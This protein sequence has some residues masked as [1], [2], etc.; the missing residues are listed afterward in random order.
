MT[1]LPPKHTWTLTSLQLM[2]STIPTTSSNTRPVFLQLSDRERNKHVFRRT[3]TG[4]WTLF[5][6]QCLHLK[7][8]FSRMLTSNSWIC[9]YLRWW[10]W[11]CP[12]PAACFCCTWRHKPLASAQC[13]W[14]PGP[15]HLRG[16][17]AGGGDKKHQFHRDFMQ[18][19][20]CVTPFTGPQGL[21]HKSL[22]KS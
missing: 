9:S 4:T 19:C 18:L 8:E 16:S 17:P 15:V 14:S 7:G 11:F 20:C 5:K 6:K 13:R 2:I 21:L 10:S 1:L 12:W 22:V 3:E